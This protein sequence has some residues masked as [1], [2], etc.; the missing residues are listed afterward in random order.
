MVDLA[1]NVLK[2]AKLEVV[3]PHAKGL[4]TRVVLLGHVLVS[5]QL[6]LG[7]A[8]LILGA[9]Q[10]RPELLD[11]LVARLQ[12]LRRVFTEVVANDSVD[13]RLRSVRLTKGKAVRWQTDAALFLVRGHSDVRADPGLILGLELVVLLGSYDA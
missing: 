12:R 13:R 7:V 10:L 1:F 3:A 4:E 2:P 9:P 11:L 6:R 8:N 5:L